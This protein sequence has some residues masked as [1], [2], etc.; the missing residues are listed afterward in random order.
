MNSRGCRQSL[1]PLPDLSRKIEG[2][3]VRRVFYIAPF[4][5]MT[6]AH[7]ESS[8]HWSFCL[9]TPFTKRSEQNTE[10]VFCP[11][12]FSKSVILHALRTKTPVPA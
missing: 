12:P 4:S 8:R 11:L 10:S 6:K 5:L 7:A 9:I 1:P 2:D 3:S